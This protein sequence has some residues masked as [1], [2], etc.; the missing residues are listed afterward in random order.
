MRRSRLTVSVLLVTVLVV[1]L[2][3][4]VVRPSDGV[5][6][7]NRDSGSTVELAVGERLTVELE[8]VPF[9]GYVWL[10]AEKP[11]PRVLKTVGPE[12]TWAP[13]LGDE[14]TTTWR[15]RAVGPGTT[16]IEILYYRPA[17]G[18]C[19]ERSRLEVVVA[20]S[21]SVEHDPAG[22]TTRG[23]SGASLF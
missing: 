15:F 2:L 16:Q 1:V 3:W 23:R 8:A 10:M 18:E 22:Q 4:M 11:R 6:V 7:T 19:M 12:E 9:V 13:I 17:R 14:V 5:T 21:Y 20:G